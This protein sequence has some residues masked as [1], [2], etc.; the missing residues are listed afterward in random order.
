MIDYLSV[1]NLKYLKKARSSKNIITKILQFG[2]AH[3]S[4]WNV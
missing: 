2:A 1:D 4:I 3:N